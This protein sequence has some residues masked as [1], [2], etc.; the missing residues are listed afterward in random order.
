[1]NMLLAVSFGNAGML[2]WMA[3]AGVPVVLHL[4]RRH[5]RHE[6][7]WAAVQFLQA[8]LERQRSTLR[9]QQ[10]SLLLVRITLPITLALALAD[11]QWSTGE[12]KLAGR[13]ARAWHHLL[14]VDT[15]ASM[16]TEEAGQ[17][18]LASAQA[19]LRGVVE[20]AR[21]GDGF[22]LLTLASA[23]RAVV[24]DLTFSRQDLLTQVNGL[25]RTDTAADLGATITLALETLT[26]VQAAHPDLTH[27]VL[28]ASD[29][30]TNTWQ[31]SDLPAQA[32]RFSA[33]M[34]DARVEVLD[35]AAPP[36]WN[37]HV[38][39][40]TR[41]T[42]LATVATPVHWQVEVHTSGDPPAY[43]ALHLEVNEE[44]VATHVIPR[45]PGSQTLH[46]TH[47]FDR[48]GDQ[49][50]RFVLTND[51][52]PADDAYHQICRV[53]ERV[54]VLCVEGVADAGRYLAHALQVGHGER[55]RVRRIAAWE[56]NPI[57]GH[58]ADVLALCNVAQ[59]SAA[60]A[61]AIRSHL[62]RGRG[63]LCF[64]G[65]RARAANYNQ[66][67]G[68]AVA[69]EGVLPATLEA[70]QSFGDYSFAPASYQHPVLAPFRGQRDS[71][72]TS[73]PIWSY[74]RTTPHPESQIILPYSSGDAAILSR[75][76]L[77]GTFVLTTCAVSEQSRVLH[78]GAPASWTAWHAWPSFVPIVQELLVTVLQ[79][80]E[81]RG[82]CSLGETFSATLPRGAPRTVRCAHD[83]GA[84]WQVAATSQT[85]PRVH[86]HETQRAGFYSLETGSDTPP[87]QF[88][89]ARPDPAESAAKS[90][91][92][93]DL[94]AAWS[95]PHPRELAS[96]S[97][98]SPH[99]PTQWL[100]GLLLML[101]V[102]ESL[103]AGR[104]GGVR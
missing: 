33:L 29:L 20:H 24:G 14:I 41:S 15:S 2:A 54:E 10:V 101:L 90:L 81:R 38:A 31:A 12:S 5:A 4:W 94:P 71:G 100:L 91:S 48:A 57:A 32:R 86:F 75:P 34:P 60:Q 59:F 58:D 63:V 73:T 19:A 104:L 78:E 83:S 16:A 87:L 7:S 23:P 6:T 102:V 40:V 39:S 43:G 9:L 72:L 26:R 18:R 70:P 62:A 42:S 64:L 77:G 1:M 96:R 88:A 49:R 74:W 21:E 93:A 66:L 80:Q 46:V 13:A 79:T 61:Q 30:G 35:V 98:G 65:D 36:V 47:R 76:H 68:D 45:E 99:T 37:R 56:W 84:A 69:R 95:G 53:R 22:T 8:A 25:S 103:L 51:A 27:H 17:S 67:L 28:I 82:H 97:T 89:V 85:P 92:A 3:A 52:L 44:R 11:P 55:L 50:V